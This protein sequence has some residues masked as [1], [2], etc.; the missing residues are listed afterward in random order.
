MTRVEKCHTHNHDPSSRTSRDENVAFNTH[1]AGHDW[2]NTFKEVHSDMSRFEILKYGDFSP[3]LRVRARVTPYVRLYPHPSP[4]SVP[5]RPR[6]E[7]LFP[8]TPRSTPW[9]SRP[10]RD[11]SLPCTGTYRVCVSVV[12]RRASRVD[13]TMT[14]DISHAHATTTTRRNRG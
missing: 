13:A 8:H 7:A 5:G 1:F 6:L 4:P 14:E 11:P 2:S 3:R 9:R 12:A 10:R